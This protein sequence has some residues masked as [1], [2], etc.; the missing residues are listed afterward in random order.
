TVF[1]E[2]MGHPPGP[3]LTP[4]FDFHFYTIGQDQR[5][6][7]DCT[8]LSKPAE[9]AAGYTLPDVTLP[10][11]MAAM[12]GTTT[13]MGL[14]VP[15]MGM[16]SLLT[17]ELE[18]TGLFRGTMVIGYYQGKPIFIEPMI[19]KEMLLEQKGFELPIPAIPGLT[20]NRPRS[21]RAEYDTAQK[22]YRFVFSDFAAGT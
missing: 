21:F 12:I 16:H 6:A 22:A 1:W 7:M 8:D 13:L 4:H 9:L 15:G 18:G 14:C 2:S 20:G 19:S 3:Y 17:S 5:M 10:P 11:P